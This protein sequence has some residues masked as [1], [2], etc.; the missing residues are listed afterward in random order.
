MQGQIKSEIKFLK[1]LNEI[2]A[3][4]KLIHQL[5]KKSM[6]H[7]I[8]LKVILFCHS[9]IVAYRFWLNLKKYPYFLFWLLDQ[10][11]LRLQKKCIEKISYQSEKFLEPGVIQLIDLG[12]SQ[13]IGNS[14]FQEKILFGSLNFVSRAFHKDEQLGYKEDLESLFYVLVYLKNQCGQQ[15]DWRHENSLLKTITLS[16]EF[17]PKFFKF[18]SYIDE[19]KPNQMPDYSFIKFL[20]IKMLQKIYL[21]PNSNQY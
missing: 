7:L 21:N 11:L 6:N 19:L 3:I 17:P 12:L 9:Y 15:I 2:E 4:P 14:K 16:Q 1:E 18:M 5:Q 8:N 20:I 13:S 10:V